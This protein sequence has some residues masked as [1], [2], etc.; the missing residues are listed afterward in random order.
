MDRE[1]VPTSRKKKAVA[2]KQ[3]K[4]SIKKAAPAKHRE[5]GKSKK[6]EAKRLSAVAASIVQRSETRAEPQVRERPVITLE[7]IRGET[8]IGD[9]LVA[10]PWTREV[11]V[12]KGLGLG[13][14][15]AGYIY[16]SLEAFSA[17]NGL[18]VEN[19]VEDVVV[20]AKEPPSQQLVQP[21]VASAPTA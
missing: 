11:L 14:E 19:L 6:T 17:M 5:I 12:R 10:F 15:D 16:M 7:N 13:A 20:V 2:K 18:S 8:V 3:K 4:K 9:L 21:L 1:R